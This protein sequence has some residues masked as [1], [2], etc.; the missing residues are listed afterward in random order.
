MCRWNRRAVEIE[1]EGIL[2]CGRQPRT[3][4]WYPDTG[5][6]GC[7]VTVYH[8][9]LTPAIYFLAFQPSMAMV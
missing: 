4:D 9:I 8:V 7:R 5:S 1:G 2:E 6:R 3:A